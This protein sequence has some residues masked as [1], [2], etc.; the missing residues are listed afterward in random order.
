MR[1]ELRL[2]N[3]ASFTKVFRGEE[4]VAEFYYTLHKIREIVLN[5]GTSISVRVQVLRLAVQQ[6][7]D[8]SL[9]LTDHE[10]N[11]QSSLEKELSR[12]GVHV[13]MEEYKT[14][15]DA[16]KEV[17]R[18]VDC[19]ALTA[20]IFSRLLGSPYERYARFRLRDHRRFTAWHAIWPLHVTNL[21]IMPAYHPTA[22]EQKPACLINGDTD[23]IC[24]ME[25]GRSTVLG[26]CFCPEESVVVTDGRPLKSVRQLSWSHV[27]HPYY[28]KGRE[29][30][31][32][33][34]V[35]AL[36]SKG[37]VEE[38]VRVLRAA[39]GKSEEFVEV[40]GGF[41]APFQIPHNRLLELGIKMPGEKRSPRGS[42]AFCVW[43]YRTLLREGAKVLHQAQVPSWFL[44]EGWLSIYENAEERHGIQ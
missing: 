33:L 32:S 42:E 44:R 24:R 18:K 34:H 30:Y 10:W 35:N 3:N 43:A 31:C 23:H 2:V 21:Y 38:L 5:K 4:V 22:N 36:R 40:S 6:F 25:G 26:Y 37:G 12:E 13:Y 29:F 27:K 17:L 1:K 15:K 19:Y 16:L 28:A 14:A 41:R 20:R 11:I 8:M 39:I 9:M 7:P